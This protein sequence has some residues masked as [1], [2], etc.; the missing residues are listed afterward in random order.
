[1]GEE[2][3]ENST[4]GAAAKVNNLVQHAAQSQRQ[5]AR[6]PGLIWGPCAV[7][8]AWIPAAVPDKLSP[9]L[10]HV[11]WAWAT[12]NQASVTPPSLAR[13]FVRRRPVKRAAPLARC[14]TLAASHRRTTAKAAQLRASPSG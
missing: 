8:S 10:K 11:G 3:S 4:V 6:A 7:I 9:V 1:V 13:A 12:A 2:R 5:T 14:L